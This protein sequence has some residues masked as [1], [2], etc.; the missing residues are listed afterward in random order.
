MI[1]KL[2]RKFIV[3]TMS[4]VTIILLAVFVAV[5]RTTQQNIQQSSMM[6]LRQSMREEVQHTE[7]EGTQRDGAPKESGERPP[8]R[9]PTVIAQVEEDGSVTILKNR[10]YFLEDSD[11]QRMVEQV[12]A[13]RE[14]TGTLSQYSLRFLWQETPSGT[15]IALTDTTLEHSIVGDL[16]RSSLVIGGGAFVLFFVLSIFLARWA[17]RPVQRAWDQQRQF[18]ADASHELKTPLTV[19]LSNADMLS[20]RHPFTDPLDVRRMDNIQAE[21]GRMKRLIE[22]ML[23]LARA[24][25]V[26][27]TACFSQVNLSDVVTDS[28]LLFE[29]SLYDDAKSLDYQIGENL[30]VQGDGDRLRQLVDILLDNAQKYSAA[31]EQITVRLE[32]VGRKTARLAVTNGGLPLAQEDLSRIFQRFYRV[33]AARVNHG[34]FGLGLA[35]AHSIAQEHRGHIWAESD[36]EKGNTFFVTLPLTP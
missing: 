29:S 5:L 2:R 36:S 25:S 9:I 32:E 13:Q 6:A 22:D 17:V 12:L 7:R 35:I 4:F 28:V 16:V 31:G 21:G 10:I 23:V 14:Y 19:I 27:Q 30:A 3:I 20:T 24:D 8:N 26:E 33:D 1:E 34:G 18:V 11:A 15:R